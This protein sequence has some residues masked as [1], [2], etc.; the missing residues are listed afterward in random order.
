MR[1]NGRGQSEDRTINKRHKAKKTRIQQRGI[2]NIQNANTLL[3]VKE[4]NIQLEEEMR[5]NGRSQGG[6][7]TTVRRYGKYGE[8]GY[9]TCICKKDKEMSNVYS[10]E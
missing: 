10:F 4:I 9:N 7:R 6:G 5:T 8:P 1:T 2:F 3:N